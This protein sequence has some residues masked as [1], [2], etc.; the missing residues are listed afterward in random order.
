MLRLIFSSLL[1][2][3]WRSLAT[4]L[5]IALGAAL[6][7][8][9]FL[10]QNCLSHGLERGR[11]QLGADLVVVPANASV[12]PDK[13]LFAGSPVHAYM[14][15]ELVARERAVPGVA[16]V[17]SQI[18]THPLRLACCDGDTE[19]RLVGIEE[20][21]LRRLAPLSALSRPALDADEVVIGSGVLPHISHPGA[22]V[23]I[24]GKIFRLA[25]RLNPTGA[26][27]DH[28]ILLPIDGARALAANSAALRPVWAEAGA[29]PAQLVSALLV[30]TADPAAAETVARAIERAGSF[31][32]IR[33]GET[34]LRLKRLLTAF[35][36]VL[37][38][39][40]VLAATA[41]SAPLFIHC[42]AAAWDRKG[43]WALYRA[44]GAS[45]AAVA[46][47]VAGETALL[48]AAG[49][50]L[51]LPAGGLLYRAAF[52]QLSAENAIPGVP[53]H[54]SL[55]ATGAL[56]VFALFTLA[57][58]LAAALPALRVTRLE[59]AAVMAREDVD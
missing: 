44:L 5:G 27:L 41:A 26:S 4:L 50:L 43:E 24:L 17:E 58:A 30:E 56:G 59:P 16:R 1:R 57:G 7:F 48:A 46:K 2:R 8:A 14:P 32:V 10:L 18:F 39:A 3:R 19:T 9:V 21:V 51:G 28:S 25:W 36:S 12:D 55:A 40:A 45:R 54:A 42:A 35:V 13:A 31:N 22:R 34:F 53:V 6:L 52:A 15:R 38:A 23:E 29:P 20:G 47:L 37:A 49:A 33:A 11:C